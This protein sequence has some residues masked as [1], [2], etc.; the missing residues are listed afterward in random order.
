M[1]S[2]ILV[3]ILIYC[4]NIRINEIPPLGKFLNPYSGFW[5][6]GEVKSNDPLENI[7]FESLEDE[8]VIQYDSSLIPHIYAKNDKDLFYA[9]G[10]LTAFHRLWQMEFQIKAASGELS[11]IL[12]E[13][14]LK[15]DIIRR[16]TGIIFAAKR[17]LKKSIQDKET[18]YLLESYVRGVNDYIKSLEYKDLPLEYKLLDYKPE[19]WTVLKTFILMEYMSDMLSRG[20]SDIEDTYLINEI[21]KNSYDNLFPEYFEEVKPII[22]DY[23]DFDFKNKKEI[24]VTDNLIFN[25]KLDL[26]TNPDP[27]NGSNNFAISSN[28]SKDGS[29]YLASQPDLSLNL[30]SI[31]YITHLNSPNF[32]TMGASLPG[33]PGI[34]IGFND[35]VA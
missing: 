8:I 9:Q 14:A 34:I 11:K 4:L 30:P 6:N 25:S 31:W 3:S 35:Y 18:Y 7:E 28:K 2:L 23:I 20:N 32:N 19:E 5:I 29:T 24:Y 21:G 12:G 10:Y 1:I 26:I 22:P 27:D 15:N 13:K 17:T 33:A 16:R